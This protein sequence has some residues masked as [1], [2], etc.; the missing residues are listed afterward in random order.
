MQT[1]WASNSNLTFTSWRIRTNARLAHSFSR[2]D[3]RRVCFLE[4]MS[5]K[6]VKERKILE[7]FIVESLSFCR[8]RVLKAL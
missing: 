4:D 8:F 2:A 7:N 1:S 5:R 6:I 3:E